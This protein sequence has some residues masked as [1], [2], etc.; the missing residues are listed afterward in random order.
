[1]PRK[2][3]VQEPE[4]DVDETL[5][6]TA[7][8]DWEWETIAEQSATRVLFDTIGDTFIGQYEGMDHIEQEPD[9]NG[10]DQSFDLYVFRGRDGNRYSVNT[11]YRLNE[12]M[13]KVS[14]SDW[15]RIVYVADIP[16][17]RKLQPMK[18]FRVDVRR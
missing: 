5:L 17:S 6:T 1:M 9:A 2:P 13:A 3:P 14:P 15:V 8:E 16:T 12:A 10:Q 18:D 11:S 7:P 4:P